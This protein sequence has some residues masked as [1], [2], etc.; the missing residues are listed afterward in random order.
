MIN[1]KDAIELMDPKLKGKFS[2]VDAMIVFELVT[3]C[4]QP[5]SSL[6]TKDLVGELEDLQTETEVSTK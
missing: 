1:G 5:E 4:L 6:S 2:V 3:K